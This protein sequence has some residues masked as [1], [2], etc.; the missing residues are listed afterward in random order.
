MAFDAS[1]IV[2]DKP[3]DPSMMERFQSRLTPALNAVGI[4]FDRQVAEKEYAENNRSKEI[5]KYIRVPKRLLQKQAEEG[6][7]LIKVGTGR[8]E[9]FRQFSNSRYA[10]TCI[11]RMQERTVIWNNFHPKVYHAFTE[12]RNFPF[13]LAS[14]ISHTEKTTAMVLSTTTFSRVS[15]TFALYIDGEMRSSLGGKTALTE[16]KQVYGVDINQ[17]MDAIDLCLSIEYAV[18]DYSMVSDLLVKHKAMQ[19]KWEEAAKDI[20]S[21]GG[22]DIQLDNDK[23]KSEQIHIL[24]EENE[25]VLA[26]LTSQAERAAA[27][28]KLEPTGTIF[29]F[30]MKQNQGAGQEGE[31]NKEKYFGHNIRSM[32]LG[33]K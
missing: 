16:V 33:E 5:N 18:A 1:I 13:L 25:R 15:D 4:G 9:Y 6:H 26:E 29:Y 30:C 20:E 28:L 19:A 3:Y 2:L 21:S 24:T 7:E 32:V 8:Y 11:C 22:L 12:F 10:F 27:F 14:V 23:P 17:A 31:P